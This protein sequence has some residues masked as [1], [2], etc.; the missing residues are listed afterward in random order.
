MLTGFT[1]AV[2]T[3]RAFALPELIYAIIVPIRT[4]HKRILIW[5]IRLLSAIDRGCTRPSIDNQN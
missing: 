1:M 3:W 2:L 4:I 5:R